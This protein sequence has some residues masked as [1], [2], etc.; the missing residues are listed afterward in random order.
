MIMRSRRRWSKPASAAWIGSRPLVVLAAVI[1]LLAAAGVRV[2]PARAATTDD[3]YVTLYGWNDNSPPGC[4]I[5][6][7]QLHSCAGG[8][9]TYSDPA[10]FATDRSELPPGTI[11][12][13]PPLDRYFIMEDDCTECDEDWTGQG[14]DGGPDYRH[15]D[16]WAGGASGDN[17]KALYSCEDNWTSNGQVPVIVNPPSNEPVANSG[18]GGP[19]FVASTSHCWQPT[20]NGGPSAGGSSVSAL[21][22]AGSGRCL[23][24][25]N[26]NSTPNAVQMQIWSCTGNGNQN[27]TFDSSTTRITNGVSG[28]CLKVKGNGTATGTPAV[29]DTCTS[30]WGSEKFKLV[31]STFTGEPSGYEIVNYNNGLCLDVSG[32][33]TANGTL[34]AWN[35]CDHAGAQDW[36]WSTR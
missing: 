27:W 17:A 21:L 15:I 16:L 8:A 20:D 10:T 1:A 32:G 18:K 9:G 7:P 28:L 30:G 24:D 36:N 34:V 22:N 3:I 4:D 26:S 6:Y 19:I 11:V 35:T 14:P 23:D 12:Y 29:L 13:F 25:P 33:E 2:A 31:A 5:A